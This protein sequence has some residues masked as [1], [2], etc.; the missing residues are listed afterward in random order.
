MLQQLLLP[1]FLILAKRRQRP[2]FVI[3]SHN[4]AL[5]SVAICRWSLRIE[6]LLGELCLG[7]IP[8]YLLSIS[9]STLGLVVCIHRLVD[10]LVARSYT[11]SL[12]WILVRYSV[13]SVILKGRRYSEV[14]VLNLALDQLLLVFHVLLFEGFKLF[15]EV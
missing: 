12:D 13:I 5:V 4:S 2:P 6:L 14:F 8:W 7:C 3:Q 10:S 1:N 11:Q 15:L 9:W